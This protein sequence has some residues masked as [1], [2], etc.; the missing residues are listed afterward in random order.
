MFEFRGP[1]S[2]VDISG[3]LIRNFLCPRL[4]T[5]HRGLLALT[6]LAG[7]SMMIFESGS[8]SR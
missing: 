4:C 2:E 6:F 5:R 8:S 7:A 1:S 3:L